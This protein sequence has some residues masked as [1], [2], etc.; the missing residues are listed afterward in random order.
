MHLQNE[1][2]MAIEHGANSSLYKQMVNELISDLHSEIAWKRRL[3]AVELGHLGSGAQRAIPQLQV[4]LKDSQSEVRQAAALALARI[5]VFPSE[6]IGPLLEMLQSGSDRDKYLAAKVL[7]RIGPVAKDAIPLLQQE[8]QTGQE[9]VRRA[10]SDALIKIE[11]G[12]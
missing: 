8:L 7:G 4:L 10:V 6:M 5:G 3:A 2:S 11:R 12:G 1:E 9:D